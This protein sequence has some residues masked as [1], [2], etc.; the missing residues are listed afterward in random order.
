MFSDIDSNNIQVSV[1]APL[2]RG[3]GLNEICSRFDTGAGRNAATRINQL[4][5]SDVE[6]F[7]EL[8]QTQLA[9]EF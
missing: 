4:L 7:S 9:S 6:H 5:Y 3:K 1:R 2:N 8:I